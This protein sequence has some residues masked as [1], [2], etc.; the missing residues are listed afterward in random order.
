M[1]SELKDDK[2]NI[3]LIMFLGH[4]GENDVIAQ[5]KK[6]IRTK[7]QVKKTS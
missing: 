1:D 5:L 7:S 3:V 6:F 2:M 4:L